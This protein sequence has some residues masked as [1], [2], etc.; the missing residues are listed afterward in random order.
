M[1]VKRVKRCELSGELITTSLNLS[2][3]IYRPDLLHTTAPTTDINIL[4]KT[5]KK[6]LLVI[7]GGPGIPS[8][9]L[10]P[11]LTKNSDSTSG[12]NTDLREGEGRCVIFFDQIGCGNSSSPSDITYYSTSNTV[13]DLEQLIRHLK[14]KEFHLYGHSYGGIIA[15]E[16]FKRHCSQRIDHED[17]AAVPTLLSITMCSAPSNIHCVDEESMVLMKSLD[18]DDHDHDLHRLRSNSNCSM[19]SNASDEGTDSIMD[20]VSTSACTT[21]KTDVTDKTSLFQQ[22]FVC[23][24]ITNDGILPPPLQEAYSK[25][26]KVFSGTDAIKGYVAEALMA[27]SREVDYVSPPPVL[28]MRGEYDFVSSKYSFDEWRELFRHDSITKKT[29]KG[30]SHY[31]MVE[32]PMLHSMVL[33]SF[34]DKCERGEEIADEDNTTDH[35]IS[36][37]MTNALQDVTSKQ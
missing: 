23:R 25:M 17:V 18:D 1:T 37:C 16:Y 11:S 9:Y 20:G 15:Y 26:G 27:L 13:N 5:K 7:H 10:Q 33:K 4:E 3:V 32:N 28:L 6:P 2:Y 12:N 14:L 35:H 30:C 8:D 36:S 29:L 19:S 34:L 21:N 22:S 24:T 31:S